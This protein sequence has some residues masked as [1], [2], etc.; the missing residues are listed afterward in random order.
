M[1]GSPGGASLGEG[2]GVPDEDSLGDPVGVDEADGV[3]SASGSAS[4][5]PQAASIDRARTSVMAAPREV[6]MVVRR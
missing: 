1:E 6:C 3:P 4:Y 5:G 2:L